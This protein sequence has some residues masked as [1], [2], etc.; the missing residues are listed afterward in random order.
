MNRRVML[1]CAA[2]ALIMLVLTASMFVRVDRV[3]P[4]FR[5]TINRT[6]TAIY[7]PHLRIVRLMLPGRTIDLHTW[8]VSAWPGDRPRE[9]I[10]P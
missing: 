2:C 9:D 3:R 6:D 7:G 10:R 4:V 1:A 8:Q 5:M